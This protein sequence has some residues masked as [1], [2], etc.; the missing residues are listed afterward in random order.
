VPSDDLKRA[1]AESEVLE[2]EARRIGQAFARADLDRLR[3]AL[4]S[5]DPSEAARVLGWTPQTLQGV[6]DALELE[7][8]EL[9]HEFPELRELAR[10]RH[11]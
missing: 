11:E 5:G 9:A 8:R 1:V 4:E 6:V 2:G 7:S 10:R 3:D